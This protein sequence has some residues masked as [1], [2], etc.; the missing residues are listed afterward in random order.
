MKARKII[1]TAGAVVALALPAAQPA[2]AQI[3]GDAGAG[4]RHG[5]VSLHK[6]SKQVKSSSTTIRLG[7]YS[8]QA[9]V[10]GGSSKKIGTAITNLG[11]K[12]AK[13]SNVKSGGTKSGSL[14][15]IVVITSTTPV[16]TTLTDYCQSSMVDCTDEELCSIWGAN[17]NLVENATSAPVVETPAQ[18]EATAP[19]ESTSSTTEAQ[20]PSQEANIAAALAAVSDPLTDELIWGS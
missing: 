17:C 7:A 15:P 10:P 5:G 18:A 12:L 11:K 16:A 13:G 14:P 9:Y 8:L 1:L 4:V 19:A 2:A 20:A 6:V 3:P